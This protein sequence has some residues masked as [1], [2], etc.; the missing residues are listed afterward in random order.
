MVTGGDGNL[1][2]GTLSQAGGRFVTA[3]GLASFGF[4]A[5]IDRNE[6]GTPDA[7]ELTTATGDYSIALGSATQATGTPL[8][9]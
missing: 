1:A 2:S 8:G 6:D 3:S 5:W 9:I 4:G 7:G